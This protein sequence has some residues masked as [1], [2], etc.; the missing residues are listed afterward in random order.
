MMKPHSDRLIDIVGAHG[1]RA[2]DALSRFDTGFD[3]DNLMA[4]LAVLPSNTHEV[5]EVLRYCVM[6]GLSVVP[7]GGRTG[8]SGAARSSPGQVILMMQRMANI[9][10]IDAISHIAIVEAGCTLQ[11]LE[12]AVRQH[13]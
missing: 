3:P 10:A 8:L 6:H 9:V 7:Q 2:G 11:A 4:G 1:V 13:V 5:A 12:E